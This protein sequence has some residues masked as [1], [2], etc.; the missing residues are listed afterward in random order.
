MDH[1]TYTAFG[2]ACDRWTCSPA[3]STQHQQRHCLGFLPGTAV[4]L[5]ILC[6]HSNGVHRSW[7]TRTTL[8]VWSFCRTV[9][10][11]WVG[12]LVA[13]TLVGVNAGFC[14]SSCVV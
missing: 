2:P 4:T 12:T 7:I 11:T 5:P 9:N 10:S 13:L 3:T 8:E 6:G 14:R 1:C